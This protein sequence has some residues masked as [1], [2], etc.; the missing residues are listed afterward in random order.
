MHI[1]SY[2][3]HI[4]KIG[5]WVDFAAGEVIQEPH[6]SHKCEYFH[7]L[8]AGVAEIVLHSHGRHSGSKIARHQ[9]YPMDVFD[10]S[11]G[12]HFGIYPCA[13]VKPRHC[14]HTLYRFTASSVWRS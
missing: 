4:L 9:L 12:N 2:C 3:R 11:L 1:L 8:Y 6:H 7:I 5:E 14:S 10:L 13:R